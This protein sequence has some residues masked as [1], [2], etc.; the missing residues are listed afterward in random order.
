MILVSER[1]SKNSQ[2]KIHFHLEN[3]KL[4]YKFYNH[5]INHERY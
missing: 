1:L 2:F 5:V 3:K 4:Y